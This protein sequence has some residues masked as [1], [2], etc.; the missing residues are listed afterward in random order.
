MSSQEEPVTPTGHVFSAIPPPL[1]LFDFPVKKEQPI[2]APNNG[3]SQ[4]L[5]WPGTTFSDFP[6]PLE[7]IVPVS[8]DLASHL[9]NEYSQ[10]SANPQKLLNRVVYDCLNPPP[11]SP[12]TSTNVGNLPLW[13]NLSDEGD[14]T[15]QFESRFESGNLRRAVQVY[16]FEYDLILKPDTET[17]GHTQWFYFSIRNLIPNQTYKLNIIN[18]TKTDSLYNKGMLPLVY[19][20]CKSKYEEVGWFRGGGDVAYHVNN[21]KRKN[22]SWHYTLSFTISTSYAHDTLYIAHCFPYTYTYLRHYLRDLEVCPQR[23]QRFR[24]RV[25]CKTLAGNNCYMLTITSFSG[26]PDSLKH[27]KGIVITARVHPGETNSSFMVQGI[28]DY[29]TGPSLDAKIL[30]DN[31]VFKIV[32]MLNPDGVVCGNYRCHLSGHDLNRHWSEPSKKLN[33][34]IYH[35]KNMIKKFAEDR[36][37]LVYLDLHG[38]SRKKN[39]FVYGCEN[40]NNPELRLAEKVFPRILSSNISYFSFSDCSFRVQRSKQ[41]S[42]RVVVWR[43]FNIINSFTLE[44]SFCGASMGDVSGYHFTRQHL[45]DIGRLFCDS[46]LDYCDPDQSKVIGIRRELELLYPSLEAVQELDNGYESD[47]SEEETVGKKKKKSKKKRKKKDDDKK[48]SVDDS[49]GNGQKLTIIVDKKHDEVNR[50]I[51]QDDVSERSEF[52]KP[53]L[54]KIHRSGSLSSIHYCSDHSTR[55]SSVESPGEDEGPKTSRSDSSSITMDEYEGF[56]NSKRRAQ[57]A[58]LIEKFRNLERVAQKHPKQS[59]LSSLESKSNRS[60]TPPRSVSRKRSSTTVEKPFSVVQPSSLS[61]RLP[62]LFV[63]EEHKE[64]KKEEKKKKGKKSKNGKNRKR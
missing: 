46:I 59:I 35:A 27:R 22:N 60:A 41:N 21:I 37:L 19:S 3:I 45:K 36:E 54:Q 32:P 38:H 17:R 47:S 15:L 52:E 63:S 14:V 8:P 53:P 10:R 2:T 25:L 56:L 7:P 40:F 61:A 64:E 55:Q 18:F 62:P 11:D 44:A 12:P 23:R 24:K 48:V 51:T 31:F 1:P 16:P 29:L 39:C 13:Y 33:P 6:S 20:L 5:L 9:S 50:S 4:P 34:T 57:S 49:N 28:I 43:E 42:A 30:R 58:S 26:D